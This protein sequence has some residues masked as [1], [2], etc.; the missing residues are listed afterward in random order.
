MKYTWTERETALALAPLLLAYPKALDANR[1]IFYKDQLRDIPPYLLNT[2]IQK[3]IDTLRFLPTIAEIRE[4]AEQMADLERNEQKPDWSL[5]WQQLEREVRRIGHNGHPVFKDKYLEEAV[6]RLGWANICQTPLT[7]WSALRGQFRQTYETI[8]HQAD[9][10]RACR[11]ALEQVMTNGTVPELA[12]KIKALY[13][14][15]EML[16]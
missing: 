13:H 16:K 6:N 9:E 1:M 11:I 8:V 7:S 12:P 10:R 3:L 5:A 2:A 14:R 4:T 15:L